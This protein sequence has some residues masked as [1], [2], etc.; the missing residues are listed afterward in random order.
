MIFMEAGR[1]VTANWFVWANSLLFVAFGLFGVLAA[2]PITLLLAWSACDLLELGLV[3]GLEHKSESRRGGI[4][5]FSIRLLGSFVF[6]G[7]ILQ[8][9]EAAGVLDFSSSS[10]STVLIVYLAAILRLGVLPVNPALFSDR[11]LRQTLGTIT[12]L[13]ATA[14]ALAIVVRTGGLAQTGGNSS[15]VSLGFLLVVGLIAVYAGVS[16][17]LSQ[18]E[19][20]GRPAWLL[21]WAALSIGS[22]LKGE[23]EASL[24]WALACLF[25]GGLAF[26]STYR[27]RITRWVVLG[28]LIGISALPFTPAWRGIDLYSGPFHPVLVLFLIAQVMLLAGYIKLA[29]RPAGYRVEGE[30]WIQVIYPFGL[31][32][33]LLTPFAPS[34][35][36]LGQPE[37]GSGI[38]WTI[39]PLAMLI[40]GGWF[41]WERRGGRFPSVVINILDAVL[42]FRW[43]SSLLA[44]IYGYLGRLIYF[45]SSVLEGE[46]GVLWVMLWVILLLAFLLLGGGA[47]P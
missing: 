6:L 47:V 3:L 29:W 11:S 2:N 45:V 19:L 42:S 31:L 21:G 41:I 23:P 5:L 9:Q 44:M 10:S 25:T 16:W 32:L 35:Y 30:R 7:A 37:A 22:A 15:F 8:S 24:A 13:V 46:G 39:G 17:R 38:A 34:L 33:L 28:G 4:L 36:L 12:R 18:D 40:A 43:L 27:D 14:T 1:A 20:D 26:L